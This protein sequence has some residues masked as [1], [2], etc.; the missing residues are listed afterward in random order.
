MSKWMDYLR[1]FCTYLFRMYRQR[2][3]IKRR[4]I[5]TTKKTEKNRAEQIGKIRDSIEVKQVHD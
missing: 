3:E 1:V 2:E 5:D 4:Q